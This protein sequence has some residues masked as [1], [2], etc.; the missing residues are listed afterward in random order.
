MAVS[1]GRNVSCSGV[2]RFNRW[3]HRYE[4]VVGEFTYDDTAVVDPLHIV[5]LPGRGSELRGRRVKQHCLGYRGRAGD[6][7]CPVRWSLSIGSDLLP[8]NQ[9]LRISK[10]SDDNAYLQVE[11][12]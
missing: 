3:V 7:L 6:S 8:D 5:C 10:R 9:Q 1:G 4:T 2:G 12:T 11:V